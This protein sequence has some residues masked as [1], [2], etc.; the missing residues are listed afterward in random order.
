MRILFD[1]NVLISAVLNSNGI[2]A[3][4]IFKSFETDRFIV[5]QINIDEFREK[6]GT[7][8]KSKETEMERFLKLIETFA[9]VL[10]VPD[11][12]AFSERKIRDVNDRP[13]LRA[14]LAGD[15]DIIVTGDKDFLEA[16]ISYPLIM[17]PMEFLD[18][19]TSP[20]NSPKVSEP[21]TK[22]GKSKK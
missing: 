20:D 19:D 22:Y 16:N 9:E 5:C 21:T 12:I 11:R 2:P 8:F 4:A 7:K 15:V 17:S 6:I 13:I 3:K 10:K 14:A 1:T 18:Y